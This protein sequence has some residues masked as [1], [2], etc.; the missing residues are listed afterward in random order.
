MHE[1]DFRYI[2]EMRKTKK[3]T[4]QMAI[5][6]RTGET[7]RCESLRVIHNPQQLRGIPLLTLVHAVCTRAVSSVHCAPIVILSPRLESALMQC[8]TAIL[9]FVKRAHRSDRARE[10]SDSERQQGYMW[11]ELCSHVKMQ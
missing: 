1:D 2:R 10:I 3:Q 9:N 6:A 8:D 5:E 11:L 7:R 4:L